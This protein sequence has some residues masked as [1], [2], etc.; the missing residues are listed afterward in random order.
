MAVRTFT[1]VGLA[2]DVGISW[3]VGQCQHREGVCGMCDLD[4]AVE[5]TVDG[6]CVDWFPHCQFDVVD[7]K[8]TEIRDSEPLDVKV[9]CEREMVW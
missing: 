6:V 8:P 7:F 5:T 9:S 1:A 3:L 4:E 2:R